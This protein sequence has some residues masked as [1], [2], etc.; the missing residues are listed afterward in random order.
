MPVSPDPSTSIIATQF[1]IKINYYLCHTRQLRV[2]L[3]SSVNLAPTTLKGSEFQSLTIFC[4]YK[5]CLT[6][7]AVKA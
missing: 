7:L 1:S 3:N 6:V 2:A 5:C 4:K